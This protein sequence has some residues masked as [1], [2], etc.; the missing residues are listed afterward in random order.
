VVDLLRPSGV[1]TAAAAGAAAYLT[2]V[3]CA[4]FVLGTI[5]VLWVIPRLGDVAAV[6]ETLAGVVAEVPEWLSQE[7]EE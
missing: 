5:R 3:F 6:L 2:V 1:V 7:T 4:A